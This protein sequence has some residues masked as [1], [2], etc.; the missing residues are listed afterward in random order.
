MIQQSD[1]NTNQTPADSAPVTTTITNREQRFLAVLT[2][3]STVLTA[4]FAS[5]GWFV[6]YNLVLSN[7]SNLAVAQRDLA[8]KQKEMSITQTKLFEIQG[9]KLTSLEGKVDE[10]IG[11]AQN[12]LKLTMDL[13]VQRGAI[14]PKILLIKTET[15][16]DGKSEIF[17]DQSLQNVGTYF[18]YVD[19]PS[20]KLSRYPFGRNGVPVDNLIQSKDFKFDPMTLGG[21]PAGL[22]NQI[23]HRITLINPD[24]KGR[25]LYIF[26]TYRMKAD[27]PAIESISSLLRKQNPNEDLSNIGTFIYSW[28]QPI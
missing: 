16:K 23:E 28:T 13:N 3:S 26:L 15:L 17:I 1:K 18:A 4:V 6:N 27:Q 7:Q 5:I 20:L 2:A 24:L 12:R 25:N 9:I 14:T 21:M 22:T 19:A 10:E 11:Y 8:E